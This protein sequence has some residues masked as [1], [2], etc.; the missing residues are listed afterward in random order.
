MPERTPSEPGDPQFGPTNPWWD[1]PLHDERPLKIICVGAGASGLLFAYKLQRSFESFELILY[2]KNDDIGGTWLENKFPGYEFYSLMV[3]TFRTNPSHATKVV[4]VIS[5]RMPMAGPS[6]P[7]QT[8]P[9][10]MRA[11][12]KFMTTLLASLKSISFGSTAGSRSSSLVLS[13]IMR[14]VNGMWRSLM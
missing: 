2:E 7:I 10:S 12:M 9:L 14:K 1:K 8:G 13:G 5:Q 6:N 11:L 3:L 4:P